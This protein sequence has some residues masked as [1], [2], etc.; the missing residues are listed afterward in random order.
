MLFNLTN[1]IDQPN[2]IILARILSA[3]PPI[4]MP[5]SVLT[6]WKRGC[7]GKITAHH[8]NGA[9][10]AASRVKRH[11]WNDCWSTLSSPLSLIGDCSATS[12]H[13]SATTSAVG[14][15]YILGSN[16]RTRYHR[17]FVAWRRLRKH[18]LGKHAAIH[19]GLWG[20]VEV[21]GSL[22]PRSKT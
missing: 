10:D 21:S 1:C 20:V 5:K 9:L 3:Y 17:I 8:R 2:A 18:R 14:E 4:I 13:S 16:E 19:K 15:M 22:V 7:K 6:P 11:V 12:P